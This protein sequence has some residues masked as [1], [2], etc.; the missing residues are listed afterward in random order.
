ML[1]HFAADLLR[2]FGAARNFGAGLGDVRCAIAA[3]KDAING[4]FNPLRFHI[5]PKR[6]A[7]HQRRR[8][9]CAERDCD[10]FSSKRGSG[11]VNWLV[12]RGLIDAAATERRNQ[13][14]RTG[15]RRR[16]VAENIAE[17]IRRDESRRIVSDAA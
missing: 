11:A 14:N 3:F 4:C 12:Q 6:F 1:L 17:K 13:A 16:F 10:I 8:Q 7:Q 5:Q 9:N 15:E 2:Q